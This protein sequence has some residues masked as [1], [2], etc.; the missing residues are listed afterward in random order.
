MISIAKCVG[1]KF[2]VHVRMGAVGRLRKGDLRRGPGKR[3]LLVEE[4]NAHMGQAVG[5]FHQHC[6][7]LK[8]LQ[9]FQHHVVPVGH[10]FAPV[11]A[12]GSGD[13]S[14]DDAEGSRRVVH[15]DVPESIAMVGGSTRCSPDAVRSPSSVPRVGPRVETAPRWWC[16]WRFRAPCIFIAGAADADIEALIGLLV[17]QDILGLRPPTT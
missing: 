6:E 7:G 5:A 11:S 17:N 9:I 12:A 14:G 16:G 8:K 2:A 1:H 4:H 10:Q 3:S 13:R 15:P